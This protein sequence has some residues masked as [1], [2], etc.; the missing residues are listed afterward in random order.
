MENEEVV[1]YIV[2]RIEK[3]CYGNNI[4]LK[5]LGGK[6]HVETSDLLTKDPQKKGHQTDSQR[7]R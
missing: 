4:H 5:G 3:T 1:F 2:S 6:K 7:K